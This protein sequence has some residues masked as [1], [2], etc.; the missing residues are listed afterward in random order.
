MGK[1]TATETMMEES[2]RMRQAWFERIEARLAKVEKEQSYMSE[3]ARCGVA[4]YLA[5]KADLLLCRR[6]ASENMSDPKPEPECKKCGSKIIKMNIG[7]ACVNCEDL[8]QYGS[9]P[10][11]PAPPL[12]VR[13]AI[14][15]EHTC[16]TDI[17]GKWRYSPKD[18]YIL[19]GIEYPLIPDYPNDR[20]AAM[21]ALE[22][23]C[24]QCDHTDFQ[25]FWHKGDFDVRIFGQRVEDY[26]GLAR[27]FIYAGQSLP[28]AIS[29]A[30][31]K[32]SEGK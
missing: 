4:T 30:I 15:L 14:C 7:Y 22:E 21:N 1:K 20:T 18:R 13:V 24:N 3:C 19:E 29:L 28:T 27:F 23:Y 12:R 25:I 26:P 31:V 8:D 16:W 5:S 2:D 11:D 17:D 9:L 10:P 6:C 32:H